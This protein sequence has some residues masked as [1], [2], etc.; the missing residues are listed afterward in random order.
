[1]HYTFSGV[2]AGTPAHTLMISLVATAGGILLLLFF[3]LLRRTVR[4]RYFRRRDKRVQF[5]GGNWQR[6]L[7]GEIPVQ[8][9]YRAKMDRQIV[10][11]N[12]L[13]RMAAADSGEKEALQ[14]LARRSGLADRRIHE[15]RASRGWSRRLALLAVGRLQLPEGIPAL[16]GALEDPHD[17]TVVD[18]VRGLGQIGTPEAGRPLVEHLYA[19]PDQC[20]ARV[21]QDALVR[22]YKSEP[23]LLME[24]VRLSDDALRPL[25]ARA[26]AEVADH[27]VLDRLRDLALDPLAEVRASAARIIALLKPPSALHILPILAEDP[28][29]FVRLR[30]A[31]AI[32][33]LGRNSG[34]PVLIPLLCDRNRFVRLRAAS[35]LAAFR[36]EE[37]QILRSVVETGDGYAM[38]S[39]ISEL[40]RS[41]RL[42]EM[43]DGLS[44]DIRASSI[45]YVLRVMLQNGFAGA[46]TDL[47]IHHPND[48][49]R[50]ELAGILTRSQ[51]QSLMVRLE[52]YK[53]DGLD[54]AQ[55]RLLDQVIS[56]LGNGPNP[57]TGKLET[58]S[59]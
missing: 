23:Q 4:N 16:S 29:W 49:V 47:M 11:E 20:P 21:V 56:G 7:S 10:E 46:I 17:Q 53:T 34:I 3:I 24:E 44:A 33:A 25:L 40:E 54:A 14:E 35:E 27:R 48:R 32:G 59:L 9:W 5:I 45:E 55:L 2:P 15:S 30:A 50:K 58:A 1:M 39:L 37:A 12:L 51:D 36:G 13:G 31:A 41:G 57:Q 43:I 22:C 26:L 28:E 8:D 52:R 18:A 42:K 19:R 6:I 38:Q